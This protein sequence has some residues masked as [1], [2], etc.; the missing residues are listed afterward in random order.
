MD[1]FK[2]SI[3]RIYSELVFAVA[4][5]MVTASCG[6]PAY[7]HKTIAGKQAIIDQV[8][9]LLTNS[10]CTSAIASVE[11]LYNSEYTDNEVRYARAAAHGCSAGIEDLVDVMT[12]IMDN[13]SSLA[14]PGFWK[15]LT[16]LF[17]VVDDT[18]TAEQLSTL[19]ESRMV[20]GWNSSDA[21][22]SIIGP[23]LSIS[24]MNITFQNTYN[25][26][27]VVVTD[28]LVN[29]NLFHLFVAMSVIGNT[30]ARFGAPDPTTFAR[31]QIMGASSGNTDG[32]TKEDYVDEA[33]CGY[34]AGVVNMLDSINDTAANLTGA[35]KSSLETIATTFGDFV[36]QACD[37]GC[38]GTL[39]PTGANCA[40]AAGICAQSSKQP[41][42]KA[43]RNRK[44]CATRDLI[45]D[46]DDKARCA[47]AGIASFISLSP[48]GWQ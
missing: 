37:A 14:G 5:L 19:H 38:Q 45:S 10:E 41:C 36:D 48:L 40:F 6:A 20:S 29:A 9:L 13:A 4:V 26:G 7:D 33:A 12:F 42:L 47:A 39:F 30:Q 23:G 2:L 35:A 17:Y 22:M 25:P 34:A 27:S 18:K 1:I 32:W 44:L 11:G 31:G 24:P 21:L 15:S 43:I 3:F 16:E 8:H 46:V 28:R